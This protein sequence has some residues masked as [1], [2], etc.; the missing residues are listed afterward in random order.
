MKN[1]LTPQTVRIAMLTGLLIYSIFGYLDQFMMPSNYNTAWIIRYIIIVP[2][3]IVIYLLSYTKLIEKFQNTLLYLLLTF[4]QVGI[5]T[6][7]WISDP[8]DPA[9]FTYYA[10][11]ILMMLWGSF[12]FRLNFKTAIYF[13][14]ST[15]ILYNFTA[16]VKQQ[17]IFSTDIT[18]GFALYLNN[19]FFFNFS[20][21]S[22]ISGYTQAR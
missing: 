18:E 11:L 10:G 21:Y 19:N 14:I 3:T 15:I 8:Q 16:I 4:G 12:I 6:M 7:I 2:L 22:N 5:T 17:I 13:S 1:K 20:S 9:F